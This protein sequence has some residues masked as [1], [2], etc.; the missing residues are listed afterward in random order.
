MNQKIQKVIVSSLILCLLS[1]MGVLSSF[2]R[3]KNIIIREW[4]FPKTPETYYGKG[5]YN[6]EMR[7]IVLP[8]NRVLITYSDYQKN[9][10]DY[11][12]TKVVGT[13]GHH[14]MGPFWGLDRGFLF[15]FRFYKK[16]IEPIETEMEILNKL[17]LGP[18]QSSFPEIGYKNYKVI[19]KDKNRIEFSGIW[20][21]K[22]KN[23][24]KFIYKALK[25][26]KE[27]KLHNFSQ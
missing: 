25:L 18:G 24:N 3:S 1:S 15:G 19:L 14:Y 12:L 4:V 13:F 2:I 16:G 8:K 23:D 10:I 22:V 7:F 6:R 5:I 20:L 9:Q 17:H 11:V 27:N 26:L 21:N